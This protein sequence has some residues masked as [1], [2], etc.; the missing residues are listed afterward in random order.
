LPVS[1]PCFNITTSNKDI[2]WPL[3]PWLVY[4]LAVYIDG[5]GKLPFL[6]VKMSALPILP[7]FVVAALAWT[8]TDCLAFWWR[9]NQ[10]R[11]SFNVNGCHCICNFVLYLQLY[12]EM[13]STFALFTTKEWRHC[14]LL[15]SS[16]IWDCTI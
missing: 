7:M 1:F 16:H 2:I 9:F 14:L 10:Q 11:V 4:K 5:T 13:T 6:L 8:S 12:L 15:W 3:M